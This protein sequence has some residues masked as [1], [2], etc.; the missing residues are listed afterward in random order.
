VWG[1]VSGLLRCAVMCVNT[2]HGP[3]PPKP[4]AA[5]LPVA[6]YAVARLVWQQFHHLPNFIAEGS[7]RLD[8]Q[9][10]R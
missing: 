5:H 1:D 3:K 10:R 4:L 7:V 8:Q 6:V 2:F 9:E